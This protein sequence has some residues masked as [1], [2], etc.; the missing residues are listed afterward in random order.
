MAARGIQLRRFEIKNCNHLSIHGFRIRVEVIATDGDTP[1]E[2]FV[3]R[4]HP[5]D[6]H[7]GL[8]PP[9]D[10]QTVASFVDLADY[11]ADA[12]NPDNDLPFFRLAYVEL[13]V[14][15]VAHYHEVWAWIQRQTAGLVAAMNTADNLV[16]VE[17]LWIGEPVTTSGTSGTSGTS[18]TS[19]TSGTSS[20]SGISE[21]V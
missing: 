19:G 5:V 6:S 21:S 12:P 3:Y 17:D 1:K 13:D 20:S 11:P 10:F 4:Q 16:P 2:V 7:T 18:E 9:P 14:R 8:V 15:S